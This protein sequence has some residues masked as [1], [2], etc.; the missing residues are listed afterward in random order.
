MRRPTWLGPEGGVPL[1]EICPAGF[2]IWHQPR[3]QGRGGGVAIIARE[4]LCL[5]RLIAPEI[6]GCESLLVKFNLGVQVGLFLT[7]LPPSCMS[8]ALP[9]LLEEVAGLAV[10]FPRLI[11]LGDF[12]L[13]SLGEASGLAQEFMA[14]MTAMDLTQVVQ[15]PTHEGWHA[16]DMVFLSEQL[17]NGLRLR[18]LEVLPLSWSDHFLLRLDFLAPI[19]PRR[20]AEQIRMFRPRRLMDPEGF[21]MALGVIPD[22]PV[23]SSAES[24]AEAWNK[25]AAEALD[26]IV[27]LRPL[28]GTRPR[29]APWFNEELREL[30]RQ[31]RRLEKRWRKSK[32]E[33]DRTLVRAHIKTY[34]VALKVARC[35]YHATLIASA[36][37]CPAALFRVTR[38]LLNQGGVGEPLQSSAEDFNTFFADKI[39]QI[40]ADLNSNWIT[41]STDN[42]SVEVTGAHTCPPVWE[43]FDLVTPDEVDKAIGA[44]SSTTCLLDPCPSWLVSAS[45]EVT[46]SWVQEICPSSPGAPVAALSGPGL[47]AHSHS[48]PHHLKV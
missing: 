27:P 5:R 41:E 44:V 39:A 42:E 2:Q 12:N 1:S 29:G 16:P 43:E 47:T 15:G 45:R 37:S 19:L 24:L 23:H 25:A 9:V 13:P 20:E 8:Q 32:S 21:Q 46:R 30:K 17:S 26:R 34:K 4:S 14:T 10:E 31:K 36:E 40:R 35:A 33:S 18:G 28:H 7:Y 3:P 38:S 22:T 11:V 48:C 6:A